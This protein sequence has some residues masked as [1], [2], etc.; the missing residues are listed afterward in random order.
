MKRVTAI[1][2]TLVAASVAF[3]QTPTTPTTPAAKPAQG[4]QP[5]TAASKLMVGDK[6]PAL[7]V[8]KWVKGDAITGFENGKVYVVEFWATWC[9]P[10]K[11]SMPH[12]SELQKE[13]KDKGVTVIGVNV[14]EDKALNT[15]TLAKVEK[16]VKGSDAMGYTVAYDGAAKS[17]DT[18]YM[19]ASGA[20]GI[21]TAFIVNQQGKIAYIGHP[22]EMDEP[23]KAVVAGTFDLEK[24][25][26]EYKAKNSQTPREDPRMALQKFEAKFKGLLTGGKF[27]EASKLGY[28]MMD[29]PFKN[30]AQGLNVI[31]WTIVDPANKVAKQDLDLALKAATRAMEVSNSK[32][33]AI[34]DTLARVYFCKGD[35]DKA[36]E[37]QKKAVALAVGPEASFKSELEQSLKEFEAAKK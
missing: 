16:F 35:I 11:V 29:G 13:F 1:V 19:K 14:W 12:L 3:A 22:M 32:S 26:A 23:L 36:I 4:A 25:K 24:A 37:T 30:E 20:E 9:G 21:P 28:E 7:A 27:E 18:N 6:A 10:C 8:E 17:M 5:A 31:A 15:E 34:T 2:A 33:A